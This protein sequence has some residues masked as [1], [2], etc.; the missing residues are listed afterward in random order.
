MK[1]TATALVALRLP[2]DKRDHIFFDDA[3]PGFGIRLRSSGSRKW[4]FQYRLGV[5][6]RRIVLGEVS[7]ITVG[8]AREIAGDLHAKVRLGGDPAAA[9]AAAKAQ[10]ANSL[11]DLVSRYLEFKENQMRLRSYRE[12]KR[13][14][15]VHAKPLSNLPLTSVDKRTIADLLSRIAAQSGDVA[16]NRVRASLSA[17]FT[18]AMCEGLADTNPVINT[19]RRAE[20][21]RERVLTD[22]ELRAI[23]NELRDDDYGDIVKLLVLT[24]QRANEIAGLRW[25]EIDFNR[26]VIALPSERT[27]NG[28]QHDVPMSCPVVAILGRRPQVD[29]RELVFGSGVGPF[30]GWSRSKATVDD[31]ITERGGKLAHW[32]PH[33][34]RR[35][36]ATRM[37]DLGIQPHAIEAVLNHVSGH[38]A[39]VAGIYNRATYAAEKRQ[40]LELWGTHVS[41]LVAG[42]KSKVV[43]MRRETGA[44]SAPPRVKS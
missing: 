17:M 25:P 23:W 2:P 19:L 37:A 6:Q 42:E 38:K 44:M 24:G 31:R 18:W 30:S 35:T 33:D 13:H 26:G 43:S 15:E 8:K 36:V 9:K 4:V 7:A 28:R 22:A 16:A 41:A 32:T 1:L 20:K 5:K 11:G 3:V 39:G 14:L 34:L 21:S 40:A 29:E 10:A 27:K 12:V